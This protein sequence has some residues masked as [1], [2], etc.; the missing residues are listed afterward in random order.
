MKKVASINKMRNMVAWA[1]YQHEG[2][3]QLFKSI[4][5][6]EKAYDFCQKNGYEFLDFEYM[7]GMEAED[8][9]IC[10]DFLKAIKII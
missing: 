7:E 10:I 4:S 6:L 5:Q 9:E 1:D 3:N 2:F 8:E